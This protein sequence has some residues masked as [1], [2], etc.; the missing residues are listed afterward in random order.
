VLVNL[1]GDLAAAGCGEQLPFPVVVAE[2]HR[3]VTGPLV[4]VGDGGVATS[5]TRLRRWWGP[6]GPAHHLVDPA[7]GLPTAG[8]WRTVT[9]AADSCLSANTATTAAVVLGDR[10]LHWLARTGLPARLVRVDG[11][12]TTLN[13][14][15]EDTS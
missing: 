13:G 14:W 6:D 10:A 2:D 15:P 9:A 1:G 7:T 8:P 11:A 12:V 4:H 5:T 3:D